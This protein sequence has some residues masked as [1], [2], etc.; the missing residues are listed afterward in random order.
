MLADSTHHIDPPYFLAST[1]IML[2][3]PGIPL[4]EPSNLFGLEYSDR[5]TT[6][7]IS[8]PPFAITLLYSNNTP[9]YWEH[10]Q[11]TTLIKFTKE[12]IHLVQIYCTKK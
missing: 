5:N 3:N 9:Y 8:V 7:R 10:N 6:D 12:L 4:I 1:F 11:S 2:T